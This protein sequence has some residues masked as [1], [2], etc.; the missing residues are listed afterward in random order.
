MTT[1]CL[2]CA[3]G[4]LIVSRQHR[5]QELML[6]TA[7]EVCKLQREREAAAAAAAG[8]AAAVGPG[9]AE[10]VGAEGAEADEAMVEPE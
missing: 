6:G 7:A 5:Q 8:A 1:K 10:A 2:A 3:D 4:A 9:A